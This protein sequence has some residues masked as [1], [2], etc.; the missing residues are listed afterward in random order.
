M[1]EYIRYAI[2]PEDAPAFLAAYATA[3][4]VLRASSF[5]LDFE[6]A[7]C[8]EDDRNFILRIEWPSIEAHLDGFRKSPDFARFLAAIRPYID[9]IDEM[10]HYA[11]TLVHT[12]G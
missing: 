11:P 3:A 6:L 4:D 2:A 9:R 5:C 1:V 8:V 10:R 12:A 7:R